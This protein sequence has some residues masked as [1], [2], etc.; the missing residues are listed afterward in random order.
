MIKL[1]VG[2]LHPFHR[3][4]LKDAIKTVNSVNSFDR[5]I[6]V[7][8]GTK[9]IIKHILKLFS[10]D[11][12]IVYFTGFGRLYT[13]FYILGRLTFKFLLI[14]IGLARVNAIFVENLDDKN[15]IA[16]VISTPVYHVNGSGFASEGFEI[17]EQDLEFSFGYIARF[18]KSKFSDRIIKLALALPLNKSLLIAGYDI[19][20]NEYHEQFLKIA[21]ERPNV[22]FIG[23][24]MTRSEISNFFNKINILLYPSKREGLPQTILESLW[25]RTPFITTATPGC[26]QLAE[27]FGGEICKPIDFEQ[28]ETLEK[29]SECLRKPTRLFDLEK[30]KSDVIANEYRKILV[31]I[32]DNENSK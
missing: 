2:E 29:K 25:H 18:S 14:L 31:E 6:S 15:L 8:V 9:N 20:S 16:K 27:E 30:Y 26:M 1:F 17:R 24:L 22:E 19:H 32:Y 23:Q 5:D 7:I 10:K 28:P 11:I 21:A 12:T 4:A 13:D 3:I